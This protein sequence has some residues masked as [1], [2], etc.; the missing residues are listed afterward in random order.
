MDALPPPCGGE[1]SVSRVL[2]DHVGLATDFSVVNDQSSQGT[3]TLH[4]LVVDR[5]G[6]IAYGPSD[7]CRVRLLGGSAS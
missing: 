7:E 3:K 5:V 2:K 6:S 4:R 1:G